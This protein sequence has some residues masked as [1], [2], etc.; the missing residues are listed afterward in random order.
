MNIQSVP[1]GAACGY[2]S[3]TEDVK[4]SSTC[5]KRPMFPLAVA[6]LFTFGGGRKQR[7]KIQC[8]L[9]NVLGLLQVAG[10]H[11]PFR[12]AQD[13]RCVVRPPS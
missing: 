9:P 12:R 4:P 10:V 8:F 3:Q 1:T 11:I 7:P 6:L 2:I 13:N 5:C